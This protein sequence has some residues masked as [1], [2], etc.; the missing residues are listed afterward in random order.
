MKELVHVKRELD[1]LTEWAWVPPYQGGDNLVD[2]ILV[3]L[4][5]SAHGG[6]VLVVVVVVSLGAGPSPRSFPA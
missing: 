3:V 6:D 5:E 1:H 4:R 2:G